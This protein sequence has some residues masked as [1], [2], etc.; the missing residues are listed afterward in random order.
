MD[1]IESQ[2]TSLTI[3]YSTVYSDA[4]ERKY[5]SSAS[6]AFV[7]GIHRWPVISLHKWPV[8]RKMFPF[9]D[10]MTGEVYIEIHTLSFKKMHLKMSFARQWAFCT[11]LI[12]ILIYA[13]RANCFRRNISDMYLQFIK[14]LHKQWTRTC[15]WNPP[16]CKTRTYLFYTVNVIG[17]VFWRRKEPRHQ[18]PWFD[19]VELE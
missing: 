14:F 3:V 11:G 19:Y 10:V 8:T 16:S 5:Q 15:G 12:I 6:L 1:A 4:D 9:D 7:R 17:A 2:I 18:Q 13:L